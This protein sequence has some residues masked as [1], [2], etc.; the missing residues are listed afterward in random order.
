MDCDKAEGGL[1]EVHA[2]PG[3]GCWRAGWKERS[4]GQSVAGDVY[5]RDFRAGADMR[6]RFRDGA[7]EWREE[8]IT[9]VKETKDLQASALTASSPWV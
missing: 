8:K 4:D 1:T 9:G 6:T 7:Y 5:S 2:Q 3:W